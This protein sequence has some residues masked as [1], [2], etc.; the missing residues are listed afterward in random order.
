MK[1]SNDDI[2]SFDLPVGGNLSQRPPTTRAF[3]DRVV[4][5]RDDDGLYDFDYTKELTCMRLPQD[6]SRHLTAPDGT[7]TTRTVDNRVVAGRASWLEIA[8]STPLSSKD[9]RHSRTDRC[10]RDAS[11]LAQ[12]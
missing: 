11:T 4:T 6:L 8:R 3:S 7:A 12:R 5:T 10:R 2:V 1:P 9:K